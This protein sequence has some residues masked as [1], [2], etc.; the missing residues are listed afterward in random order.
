MQLSCAS[1]HTR[2]AM[3]E[4]SQILDIANVWIKFLTEPIFEPVK[5]LSVKKVY[6]FLRTYHNH[7]NWKC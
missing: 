6:Q 2:F 3:R 5:T 1:W 4:Y 7:G